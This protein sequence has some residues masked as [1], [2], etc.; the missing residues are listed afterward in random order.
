MVRPIVNS[1]SYYGDIRLLT[2]F[3]RKWFVN[4]T[5]PCDIEGYIR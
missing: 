5:W 2:V 1:R 3:D 4:G